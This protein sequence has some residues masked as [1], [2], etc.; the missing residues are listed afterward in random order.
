MGRSNFIEGARPQ[1]GLLASLRD[2]DWQE[3]AR[4]AEPQHLSLDERLFEQGEQVTHCFFPCGGTIVSLRLQSA[5]G[6]TCEVGTIGRE[7]AAGGMVSHGEAPAFTT[8][9]VAAAGLALRIESGALEELKLANPHVRRLF[10]RYADCLLAQIMQAAACHAL[11]DVE[12]RIA[13]WLL[14]FHDRHGALTIP[15]TQETLAAALG[16]GRPYASQQLKKLE[17]KGL[18]R[19]RRG[20]IE[21][22]DRRL[23]ERDAC[24]CYGAVKGHFLT[25]LSGL[26]PNPKK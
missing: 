18:I 24:E 16:V 20:A 7:G 26:Y 5:D 9:S 8:A 23:V 4:H 11:H 17:A 6:T 3:V 13:R 2:A 10:A 15:V 22:V 19:R 21:I 14:A 25:V 1:N 12:Q